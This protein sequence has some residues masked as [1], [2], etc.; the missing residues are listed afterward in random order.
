MVDIF[1]LNNCLLDIFLPDFCPLEVRTSILKQ[2]SSQMT[3]EGFS[4]QPGGCSPVKLLGFTYFLSLDLRPVR[5]L[6]PLLGQLVL[7]ATLS[8]TIDP[9]ADQPTSPLTSQTKANGEKVTGQPFLYRFCTEKLRSQRLQ[10]KSF[11]SNTQY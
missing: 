4:H 3:C 7:L 8:S 6:D 2:G 5:P 9:T 10:K 1:L 11:C